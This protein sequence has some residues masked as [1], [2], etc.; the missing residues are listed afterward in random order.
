[1]KYPATCISENLYMAMADELVAGGYADVGYTYVNIDDCWAEMARDSTTGRMVGDKKRFPSGM[2]ALGDYIHNNSLKYGIYSDVGTNTC[3]GFPGTY[4]HTTIDAQTFADWGVDSLKLDG[5]YLD[6]SQYPIEYPKMSVALNATNRPILYACSWPAYTG[7]N[8]DWKTI[9]HYCNYYR[10]WDDIQDSWDSVASIIETW[11]QERNVFVQNAGP[12]GP[13]IGNTWNDPDM[14]ICG[15]FSLSID[16]C[17][18]QFAL[19][20][21]FAAP[22]YL[23]VDLRTIGDDYAAV[24]TN[25]EVIAVDQ[26]PLGAPYNRSISGTQSVWWR[27]MAN[28]DIVV[29]LY[30]RDTGGTPT[31][32][33]FK[34]TDVGLKTGDSRNVRDLYA[35]EDIGV[36]NS[37]YS[38]DVNC[39]SAVILRLSPQSMTAQQ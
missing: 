21:L 28:A 2:K 23:S 8:S 32:I 18:A 27:L 12:G 30:N 22:L 25:R 33:S 36:F 16:E 10:N 6:A 9:R 29:V 15:D 5:C 14:I 34:W 26:D 39:H 24:I 31:T 20:S 17:K 7:F 4:N 13:G 38:Q 1:V 11:G 19:W 37:T 3:G 35:Y